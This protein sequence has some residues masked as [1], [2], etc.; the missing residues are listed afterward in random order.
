MRLKNQDF[1]EREDA[2]QHREPGGDER[3]PF[4]KPMP[5]GGE[6]QPHGHCSES[7]LD[8][9]RREQRSSGR[10]NGREEVDI[11]R[12]HEERPNGRQHPFRSD[13]RAERD[14]IRSVELAVRLQ[15]WVVPQLH[16]DDQLD[17][18]SRCHDRCVS[19]QL[20][21]VILGSRA[22]VGLSAVGECLLG[23]GG[24]SRRSAN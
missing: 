19:F 16:Q 9:L 24:T 23:V 3:R 14:V 17:H 5:G 22:E 21:R 13:L 10:E 7:D 1:V 4:A 12:R 8:Q 15:Q 11:Q 20:R 6:E 18:E 2:G